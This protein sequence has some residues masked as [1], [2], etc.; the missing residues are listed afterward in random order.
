[1]SIIKLS[2]GSRIAILYIGFVA[3]IVFLVVGSMRQSFDLVAPDYYDQELK[4]QDVI[5]AGK[6][7]TALS[8][9]ASVTANENTVRIVFPQEFKGKI[10]KGT[11]QF[12]SPV[13]SA[14]DRHFD[15]TTI[16]NSMVIARTAIQQTRY[17]VKISWQADGKNYYQESEINLSKK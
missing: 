9:P 10:I 13:N 4:Y 3:L 12:Y 5:D 16:D 7:Q 14:W 17:K 15:L 6:N 2:W 11:A 1:M 8:A